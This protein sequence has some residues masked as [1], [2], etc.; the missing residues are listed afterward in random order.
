MGATRIEL[1]PQEQA[2]DNHLNYI[3][4]EVVDAEAMR[5]YLKSRG[6]AV[7]D[8]VPIGRIGNLNFIIRDPQGVSVEIVQYGSNSWTRQ[9][10]DKFIPD[11]RIS[12]RMMH[13]G[14][15]VTNLKAELDFYEGVLGFREF[16]PSSRDGQTLSW[17]NLK[18]PDSDD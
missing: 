10:S 18:L 6:V 2:D 15:V 1:A 13:V 5:L 8:H 16:W 11:T 17:I 14:F 4:L 7:P 12:H 3:A 9:A